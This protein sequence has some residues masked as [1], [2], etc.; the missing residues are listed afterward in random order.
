MNPQLDPVAA[1]SVGRPLWVQVEAG[2]HVANTGAGFVGTVTAT[3]YG[4]EAMDGVGARR[5]TFVSLTDAK[6]ALEEVAGGVAVPTAIAAAP[7]L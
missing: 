3:P 5:G 6:T 4:Y 1:P 2:L 7:A